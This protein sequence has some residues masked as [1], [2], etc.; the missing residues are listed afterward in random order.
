MTKKKGQKDKKRS[1]KN[2]TENKRLRTTNLIN[3]GVNSCVPASL[4]ASVELLLLQTRYTLF[5]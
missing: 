1:Q 3:T 4:V 5:S 2:S